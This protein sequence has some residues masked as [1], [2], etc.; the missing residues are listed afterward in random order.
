MTKTQW[1]R[2]NAVP[3]FVLVLITATA[4]DSMKGIADEC[5]TSFARRQLDQMC[6]YRPDMEGIVAIDDP[7]YKWVEGCLDVGDS[8]LRVYWVP[9]EPD[10]GSFAQHS[11]KYSPFPAQVRLTSDPTL[12][13]EDRWLLLIYELHNIDNSDRFQRLDNALWLGSMSAD[14]YA[15]KFLLLE[16]GAEV[17]TKLFLKRMVPSTHRLAQCTFY[18]HYMA[19]PDKAPTAIS[20]ADR[21]R[22]KLNLEAYRKH[23]SNRIVWR[24]L[25]Q[26]K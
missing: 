1:I 20:R 5:E 10:P 21:K 19:I 8:S 22:C 15:D 13:G 18:Q 14:E 16:L 7:V 9:L 25:Y 3:F 11:P 6:E 24:H 26:A 2:A 17:R 23:A 12:S 4:A